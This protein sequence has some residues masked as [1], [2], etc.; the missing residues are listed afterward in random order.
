MGASSF[1]T[2]LFLIGSVVYLFAVVA[3][4]KTQLKEGQREHIALMKRVDE[5][6]G[7]T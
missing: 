6:D 2:D 5:I 7:P 3:K 1:L 4:L